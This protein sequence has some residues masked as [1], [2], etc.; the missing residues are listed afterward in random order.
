MGQLLLEAVL[1]GLIAGVGGVGIGVAL[2]PLAAGTVS[3]WSGSVT[4]VSVGAALVTVGA[5]V[6]AAV[7]AA[8][9]PAWRLARGTPAAQLGG[10]A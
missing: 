5:S 3:V 8:L 4:V 10:G 1:V 2:M 6:A 7:L 9:Y